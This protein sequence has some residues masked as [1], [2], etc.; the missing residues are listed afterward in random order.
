MKTKTRPATRMAKT[1]NKRRPSTETPQRTERP[2]ASQPMVA[3]PASDAK[4]GTPAK[5]EGDI[6]RRLGEQQDARQKRKVT[7]RLFSPF[8]VP[9]HAMSQGVWQFLSYRDAAKAR[10]DSMKR[11]EEMLREHERLRKLSKGEQRKYLASIPAYTVKELADR[12]RKETADFKASVSGHQSQ[13]IEAV[14]GLYHAANKGGVAGDDPAI[15]VD[16]ASG[17][18]TDAAAALIDLATLATTYAQL[19]ARHRPALVRQWARRCKQFPVLMGFEMH[20]KR[21]RRPDWFFKAE[22]TK[23]TVELGADTVLA[24]FSTAAFEQTTE[25]RQYARAIVECI[26]ETRAVF[27]NREADK[28]LLAIPQ[29]NVEIAFAPVPEWAEHALGLDAF[30]KD[31]AP[32][33]HE[34][35][36]AMVR[37]QL[38][39]KVDAWPLW[40]LTA[41][42]WKHASDGDKRDY[43]FRLIRNALVTIAAE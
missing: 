1:H 28:A 21:E 19:L 5:V 17:S 16:P 25:A 15:M 42:H 29:P 40:K 20:K 13:G 39:D 38:G 43:I 41:N 4:H 35:G 27:A 30:T 9:W 33:W 10:A 7:L 34:V 23:E 11:Y 12:F 14:L 6:L 3:A 31:T 24:R 26:E 36:K 8:S 18:E 22:E 32:A 2:A 37:D